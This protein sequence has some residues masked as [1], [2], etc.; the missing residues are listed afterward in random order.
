MVARVKSRKK[1][2]NMGHCAPR[3][4]KMVQ[5]M[6][7]VTGLGEDFERGLAKCVQENGHIREPYWILFHA[8]WQ[9]DHSVLNMVFSPRS[10]KPPRMLNTICYRVDNVAGRLDNEWTLPAD[11]PAAV[12]P[13]KGDRDSEVCVEVAEQS[14]GMPLVS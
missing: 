12:V 9:Q 10:G 14:V 11:A 2:S 13:G 3:D 8:H 4:F 7:K 1:L 6:Q 5:A